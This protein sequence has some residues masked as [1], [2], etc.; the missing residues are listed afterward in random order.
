[1]QKNNQIQFIP[2]IHSVKEAIL[3]NRNSIAEIWVD[4]EKTSQRI[5]ELI[6]LAEKHNIPVFEKDNATL[7]M[8]LPNTNH[9]G[10]TAL[11]EGFNYT[12]LTDLINSSS[13]LKGKRLFLAIDHITDE[14]NLG[15]IIR[16][17]AFFGVN[18]VIIPK[19]RSAKVSGAV[20]K[21]SSGGYNHVPV[22]LVVN[23]GR[24]IEQLDEAGFWI[25]G[26]S[27]DG[28]ETIYDFKFNGD[29]L[30]ILGNEEKGIS[31]VIFKRCHQ[32]LNIPSS[33]KIHALNVSVAA[34]VVI[35]EIM[36]QKQNAI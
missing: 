29:I 3:N 2:G 31:P 5:K 34:G 12:E 15:A 13:S 14:G 23:L 33:G 19:D 24:A 30:L 6:A 20:M 35:S 36:R 9:Q 22:S 27:G 4:Q 25:I 26:T 7:N 8:V 21:R 28:K 10:I 11:T 32:T 18:G 16:T 17:A 1:M